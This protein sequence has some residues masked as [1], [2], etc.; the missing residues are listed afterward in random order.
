[1]REVITLNDSPFADIDY[2]FTDYLAKKKS[3]LQRKMDGNGLP[4]YAY[5]MD[6]EYRKKLDSIPGLFKLARAV[7]S[8]IAPQN[9]MAYNMQGVMASPTQFKE[10]Y[11]MAARSAKILGIGIPNVLVVPAFDSGGDFNA[12]AY[13]LDDQE[14][15]ILVTGL[16]VQRMTPE[17]L[18]AVIAHECGHIHNYHSVYSILLSEL[19]VRGMIGLLSLPG[20]RQFTHALTQGAKFALNAFSRAAEVTADRAAVICSDNPEDAFNANKKLMYKGAEL[21]DKV[22]INL[23]LNTLREQFDLM[24]S[25]PMRYNE[26][27]YNHPATVKRIFAQM[28]FAQSEMYY[29]WRPDL[30]KPSKHLLTRKETDDRVKSYIEIAKGKGKA[31]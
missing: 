5:S 27:Y 6:Y 24:K 19:T 2:R 1:M 25:N 7:N 9:L 29:E 3:E 10:I 14:P 16:M 11:E 26:L 12:C 21:G 28:E 8:T 23:D 15:V 30:K 31:I 20:V 17:E 4:N 13:A 22:D 18:N